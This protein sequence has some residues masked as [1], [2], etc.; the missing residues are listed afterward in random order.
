MITDYLIGSTL[1]LLLIAAIVI[2]AFLHQKKV[3]HLKTRL[4]EE[5]IRSQRAFF[6][7]VQEGEER[8]RTRLAEELHDGI[9][10]RL[11]GLKMS[12]E[13][14]KQKATEQKELIAQLLTG[15]ADTLEEVREISHNLQPYY[16]EGSNM[17]QLLTDC[18]ER[19]SNA[20]NC[21]Y[22]LSVNP[23]AA[24]LDA[25]TKHQ[26]YRI[27][28]EL[29]TNIHKH[30]RASLVSIQVNVEHDKV[31]IAVEDNG[32]GFDT[33]SVNGGSGLKNIR[34]RVRYLKGILNIDSSES[35]TSV[36]IEIPLNPSV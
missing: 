15:V 4:H 32:V 24:N 14:L 22:D 21:R 13:Y 12:L 36:V 26:C 1:P 9:G 30:A 7:A 17:E 10:A 2:Y 35:G 28:S 19:F 6:D 18:I 23:P 8:E 11:S 25:D 34:N 20:D 16:F 3:L 5:E 33:S 31:E 29:L 27:I